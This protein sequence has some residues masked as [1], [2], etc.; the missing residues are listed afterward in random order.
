MRFFLSALERLALL[1]LPLPVLAQT[2]CTPQW[3][4]TFGNAPG[5]SGGVLAMA[6]HDDGSGPS[7]FVASPAASAGQYSLLFG[8]PI[9]AVARWTGSDFT[10]TSVDAPGST[11][12]LRSYDDGSGPK[13]YAGGSFTSPGGNLAVWN[14]TAWSAV[15]GSG[16]S[17]GPTGS[18]VHCLEVFD[19]GAGEQLFIGGLFTQAGGAPMRNLCRWDGTSFRPAGE[20]DNAVLAL[21]AMT[22]AGQS[23]LF[24]GGS[25]LT[26]G[27]VG[28]PRLVA[29]TAGAWI[30]LV[31]PG[32][33]GAVH[34]LTGFDFGA[35]PELV[36]AGAAFQIPGTVSPG[37]SRFN[38][39]SWSQI[40]A[41]FFGT[42]EALA[43]ADLGAGP[44]LFLTG[45][46]KQSNGDPADGLARWSGAAWLEVGDGL[47]SAGD[48]LVPFDFGQ[49]E[50]LVV[51]GNFAT[52]GAVHAD[53][54]ALWDGAAFQ[55]SGTGIDNWARAI[56]EDPF[57]PGLVVGGDFDGA[58]AATLK[59]IARFEN[60][61]F[62]PLGGTNGRVH[63]L[64]TFDAGS[65]PE[66]YAAGAFTTVGGVPARNVAR[67][68]GGQWFAL[69]DGLFGNVVNDLA[70]FDDGSG[71]A[72]YAG[73]RFTQSG[74]QLVS[75][76]AR[77]DG[78]LWQPVGSGLA[79]PGTFGQV[80]DLEVFD[81]GQGP[82]LYAAGFFNSPA[83][84]VARW[85]GQAWLDLDQGL[86]GFPT[87]DARALRVFDDGSGPA[88][89][90]AGRF[91]SVGSASLPAANIA[92][93][94]NGAWST[95]AG[96]LAQWLIE[97]LAV[98]DFGGGP[99]LVAAGSVSAASGGSNARLARWSGGQWTLQPVSD[100]GSV[101][102]LLSRPGDGLYLAGS[103][104]GDNLGGE[105]FLRRLACGSSTI[106]SWPGC[107]GPKPLLSS[108]AGAA[109]LGAPFPL[110]VS[111]APAGAP[112]VLFY[113]QSLAIDAAGCGLLLPGLG[114][115]LLT[116]A[117]F[118]VEFG[119][120]IASGG[121]AQ[122][123]PTLPSNP[124]LI[125]QKTALQ[126]VVIDPSGGGSIEL[127]NALE[128][129][130]SP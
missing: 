12:V 92:R 73:G 34:T 109:T 47:S 96:G 35:G 95:L 71:P 42:V 114:E 99:E 4:P 59:G 111:G 67:Y 65:G 13:L 66:L 51:G 64:A 119:L 84:G 2:P 21:H 61:A 106:T 94:R 121:S 68:D 16:I 101:L 116:L 24:V 105:S 69:G 5:A 23:R 77:W 81:D 130:F 58:G 62:A 83:L 80:Y 104:A 8:Q 10:G 25:F 26:V 50:R 19:D 37:V 72:L 53:G 27:G 115:L 41:P 82:E 48:S 75:S 36:V 107:F 18:T 127:S 120:A 98:H 6:V 110:T 9:G 108:S 1:A 52:A 46:L 128:V 28:S 74:A 100:L 39:S 15:G 129:T 49:G 103:F 78:A 31:P 91:A 117:P 86:G 32:T 29:R 88:L 57:G 30:P 89:F 20:P 60:G 3:Q 63:G 79:G 102:H 7:L 70:V 85:N 112:L 45:G 55:G 97:D 54:F 93:W 38:G 124:L 44:E 14:G 125:G 11:R 56:A 40:G 113:A 22:L 43:A 90:V 17:G 123:S 76:V 126:S 122:I 33:S 118:P 87:A